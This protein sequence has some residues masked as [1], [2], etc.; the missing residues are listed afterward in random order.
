MTHIPEYTLINHD[1]P[2]EGTFKYLV[3]EKNKHKARAEAIAVYARQLEERVKEQAARLAELEEK[4]AKI[5]ALKE[6]MTSRSTI[7]KRL[8]GFLG[9]LQKEQE[10]VNDIIDLLK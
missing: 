3:A 10:Y 2:V 4:A 5:E 8:K 7:R 1:V 6:E 9:T